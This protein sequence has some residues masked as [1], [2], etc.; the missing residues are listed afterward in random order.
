MPSSA[1]CNAGPPSAQS[2]VPVIAGIGVPAFDSKDLLQGRDEIL[3]R[4]HGELYRLRQT[5]NDKLILTK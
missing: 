2:P 5:R 4:H 1:P 3:I